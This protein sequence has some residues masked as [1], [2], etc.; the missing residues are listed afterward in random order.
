MKYRDEVGGLIELVPGDIHRRHGIDRAFADA[1]DQVHVF[2][3]KALRSNIQ[4]AGVKVAGVLIELLERFDIGLDFGAV[5][6]P[7]QVPEFDPVPIIA[8]DDTRERALGEGSGSFKGHV[9]NDATS[10]LIDGENGTG[11]S[12]SRAL[13]HRIID[14]NVRI[15]LGFIDFD[16]GVLGLGQAGV[17]H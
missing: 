10:A 3:I 13:G 2:I 17:I 7:F 16:N 1:I 12:G 5:D 9:L 15:T 6:T 11:K 4:D 14:R 8:F